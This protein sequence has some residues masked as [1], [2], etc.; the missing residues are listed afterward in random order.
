VLK[1]PSHGQPSLSRW[2]FLLAVR[3]AVINGYLCLREMWRANLIRG[4][5]DGSPPNN[6]RNAAGI[7]QFNAMASNLALPPSRLQAMLI[8]ARSARTVIP[9]R[10]AARRPKFVNFLM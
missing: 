3:H 8:A 1:F 10:F 2:F 7:L 9:A 4:V 6:P 5:R